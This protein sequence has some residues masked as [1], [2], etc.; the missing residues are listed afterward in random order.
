MAASPPA[1]TTGSPLVVPPGLVPTAE[2]HLVQT[3]LLHLYVYLLDK[4]L[5]GTLVLTTKTGARAAVSF[6]EGTPTRVMDL[7]GTRY[8]ERTP[9]E[10]A[11]IKLC[12]V[13]AET[14]YAF[15][16]GQDL[17]AERGTEVP[18]VEPLAVIM[19]GARAFVGAPQAEATL[20]R[21]DDVPMGIAN[22]A[23]PERFRLTPEERAL[24]ERLRK[25]RTTLADLVKTSG[26]PPRIVRGVVYGMTITRHLDF[27][28]STRPPVG[29]ERAAAARTAMTSDPY[30]WRPTSGTTGPQ[31]VDQTGTRPRDEVIRAA[32]P[33]GPLQTVKREGTGPLQ[34]IKREGT[35][36]LQAVKRA[37]D[38]TGPMPPDKPAPPNNEKR[39]A[40]IEAKLASVPNED[41]FQMLGVP[42]DATSSDVRN[43]YFKLALVYHPDKLPKDLHDLKPRV[44]RLFAS[45]NGAY[46]ALKDDAGRAQYL[47]SLSGAVLDEQAQIERAVNAALEFEKA[48][49]FLRKNDLTSCE[50]SVRRAVSADPE[51]PAYIALLAWVV[52]SRR[53]LPPVPEEGKTNN[54]YDDCITQLD[55]VLKAEPDYEKALL[56]RGRLLKLAGRV[57]QAYR[58]FKRV[59]VVNPKNIEA[60]REVRLYE[61]R[62]PP[63]DDGPGSNPGRGLLGKL[64]NKKR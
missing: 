5:T 17:L 49:V 10:R 3:P 57:H 46:A 29:L 41:H 7:A 36:P 11:M 42:R 1:P 34:A 61:M 23:T 30:G 50:A 48:E 15:Y 14:R 31:Y 13:E 24:V 64:F 33:T 18:R 62:H 26:V 6:D 35:G 47:A 59:T 28:G 40:E 25:Q 2:A 58:D 43:A 44:A 54:V 52:A 39:R 20:R 63:E 37:S 45:I 32:D 16:A 22:G 53:P 12:E 9:L 55:G 27:G 56:Y 8:A 51:Q 60:A 38:L 4:L 21:V 19:A